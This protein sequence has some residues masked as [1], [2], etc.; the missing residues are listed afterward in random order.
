M[1]KAHPL[2]GSVGLRPACSCGVQRGGGGGRWEGGGGETN[3]D[4][5]TVGKRAR[6]GCRSIAW[7]SW[8]RK[9][10]GCVRGGGCC[11]LCANNFCEFWGMVGL[12]FFLGFLDIFLWA[13]IGFFSA[14]FLCSKTACFSSNRVG[15]GE[16]WGGEDKRHRTP[17]YEL[18]TTPPSS[19]SPSPPPLP[20][21]HTESCGLPLGEWGRVGGEGRADEGRGKCHAEVSGGGGTK[22]CVWSKEQREKNKGNGNGNKKERGG[23]ACVWVGL[24]GVGNKYRREEGGGE[25]GV[26]ICRSTRLC[27]V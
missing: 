22:G 8:R 5:N 14:F 1:P 23:G 2:F 12:F 3:D 7:G 19:L 20:L 25:G 13:V 24:G 21:P 15:G 6:T 18:H 11:C 26:Y 16:G 9:P 10:K 4:A 17:Q 27:I